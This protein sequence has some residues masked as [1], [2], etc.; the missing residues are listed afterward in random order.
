MGDWKADALPSTPQSSMEV[1]EANFLF[2][3]ND[4]WQMLFDE[5][6]FSVHLHAHP[7]SEKC[8]T[9]ISFNN[10]QQSKIPRKKEEIERNRQK[11][12]TLVYIKLLCYK[13]LPPKS[14]KI[15]LP[16]PLRPLSYWAIILVQTTRR[17]EL[18]PFWTVKTI[19]YQKLFCS[20]R[21]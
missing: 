2:F 10:T 9:Y 3:Q 6:I 17:R 7:T 14:F 4:L 12:K 15:S 20:S 8:T 11:K 18:W 16:F 13:S 19:H 21:F 5:V 1:K